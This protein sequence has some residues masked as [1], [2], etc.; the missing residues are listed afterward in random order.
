MDK[1]IYHTMRSLGSAR[2]YRRRST[3]IS[4]FIRVLETTSKAESGVDLT[5]RGVFFENPI[6]R[7]APR[8]A[9]PMRGKDKYACV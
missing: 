9:A 6:L 4:S 5:Q 1:S 7:A 8:R 2:P 3:L